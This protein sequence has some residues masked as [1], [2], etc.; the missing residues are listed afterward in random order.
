MKIEEHLS[1]SYD[2]N[3][4]VIDRIVIHWFGKGTLKSATSRFLNAKNQVSAH[5][6]VSDTTVYRWVDENK[7]AY[8]AGNYEMNQRSIG[9]EHD[10]TTEKEA[11]EL[12]YETSGELIAG[13]CKRHPAILLD[14]E[15]IILHSSVKSTQCPGT[16]DINKLISIAKKYH[17]PQID[18]E[19]KIRDLE[20][21][22]DGLRASRDKHREE[23]KELEKRYVEELETKQAHLES[24]QKNQSEQNQQITTLTKNN[25]SLMAQLDVTK[26][27]MQTLKA[28]LTKVTTELDKFRTE[29][30]ITVKPEDRKV[31]WEAVKEPLRL[32]VLAV[33]S[34]AVVY[35]AGLE[36]QTEF[37]VAL[38]AVLRFVDKL[39]Y[40]YGKANSSEDLAKGLTRF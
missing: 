35:V 21:E 36:N 30:V 17:S 5:Y 4:V 33:V 39:L 6:G 8:H 10:A 40:E 37:T 19:T 15:H 34:F 29:E 11:S 7:V 28:E 27:D 38:T 13:I 14:S 1:P 32:G 2:D 3:R 31:L 26:E 9:I 23:K 25:E 12:T 16:L 18:Y 24:L 22:I 20:E